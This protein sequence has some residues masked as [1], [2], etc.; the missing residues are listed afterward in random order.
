[1]PQALQTALGSVAGV[2]RVREPRHDDRVDD[3]RD[4]EAFGDV[5]CRVQLQER[6]ELEAAHDVG[7]AAVFELRDVR[8]GA[9][10]DVEERDAHDDG[11][12]VGAR[13]GAEDEHVLCDEVGVGDLGRFGQ[14]GRAGGEEERRGGVFRAGR[15]VPAHPVGCAMAEEGAPGLRLVAVG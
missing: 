15:R 3:R 7:G 5:E 2:A 8:E 13:V 12:G 11:D 14:A 4:D 1:M 9:E 6:F 10:A